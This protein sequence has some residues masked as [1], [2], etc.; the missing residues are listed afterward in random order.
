VEDSAAWPPARWRSCHAPSGSPPFAAG[1]SWSELL[2]QATFLDRSQALSA[3]LHGH[4][5]GA[6]LQGILRE[7][8]R[9]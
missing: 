5:V 1:W 7:A 3:Q 9:L 2:A 6:A 8:K 4:D